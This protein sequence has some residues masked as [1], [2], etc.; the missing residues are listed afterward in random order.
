MFK[1]TLLLVGAAIILG[2]IPLLGRIVSLNVL[3]IG[4]IA[5]IIS[6]GLLKKVDPSLPVDRLDL[7]PGFFQLVGLIV[8]SGIASWL[9]ML[10]TFFAAWLVTAVA[11][12]DPDPDNPVAQIIAFFIAPVFGLVPVFIY[13]AWLGNQLRLLR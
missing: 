11:S 3:F 13:G 10:S 2:L 7:L 6:L 9:G 8:I 4:G 5:L 1:A 12:R